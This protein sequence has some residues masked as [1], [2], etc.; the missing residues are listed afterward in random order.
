[1][2]KIIVMEYLT[3]DGVLETPEKW[4]FPYMSADVAEFVKAQIHALEAMLLGRVT[5]EIFAADW[6]S[7]THNEFGIADK[8]NSQPKFVVSSTLERVEWNNSML[9]KK[10]VVEEIS[11]LKQK[12]G[13]NIGIPGSAKLIQSLM[14]YGII[15]EY[16]LLIHP[17]VLGTGQRLFKDGSWMPL[18]LIESEAFSSGVVLLRYQLDRK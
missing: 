1:M 10:N 6:P 12:P 11:R 3:I 13:G 9:I 2:R 18:K 17:V 5:Y 14:P 8:L 4:Q 15:D 7:R 16:Q